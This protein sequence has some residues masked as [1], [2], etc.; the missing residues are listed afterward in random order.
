MSD[1]SGKLSH[2]LSLV[3]FSH[4]IFA[5]PFALVGFALGTLQNGTFSGRLLMLV[6]LCMVFART[7]AMAFNRYLDRDIDADNPRTRVREIPAGIISARSALVFV[8]VNALLFWATTWFINFL[9]FVLAPVALLVVLGYS[10]TKR[11]TSW[12]HFVLGLGLALA[13]V[14]AYIAVTGQF[15]LVSI[16]YGWVVLTWVSGFDIIYALQDRE[17]DAG[18][19]L[20]SIPVALGGVGALRLSALLH[21]ATGL[22]LISAV[23]LQTKTYPSFDIVTWIGTL[24]FLGLLFYQHTL[25]KVHDLS[26]VNLAFFTTNGIASLV[27]GASVLLDAFG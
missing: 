7:A 19:G 1:W 22:L 2:Y 20:Q 13:P 9:C 24:V 18:K 11:F 16:L 25:V 8:V 10:Y 27:F 6:L 12:C 4:T 23:Y 14:G 3:K 21:V 17:F 15:G 26:K 5:L